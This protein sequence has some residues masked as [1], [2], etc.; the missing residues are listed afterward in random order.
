MQMVE[1]NAQ[2]YRAA[3]FALVLIAAFT[4][5]MIAFA[6]IDTFDGPLLLPIMV[7]YFL[8]NFGFVFAAVKGRLQT[9]AARLGFT[10][11]LLNIAAML[12]SDFETM[13]TAL[14]AGAVVV[15][16]VA[17]YMIFKDARALE[18]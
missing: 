7:A 15:A 6:W 5:A 10:A 8:F 4:A 11:V 2:Q 1:P 12:L 14:S 3:G 16:V 9:K 18:A 13:W 17:A